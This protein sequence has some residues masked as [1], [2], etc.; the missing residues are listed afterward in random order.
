M[1]INQNDLWLS[2]PIRLGD[3]QALS[4]AGKELISQLVEICL[5]KG[6]VPLCAINGNDTRADSEIVSLSLVELGD[7]ASELDRIQ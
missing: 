5:A 3:K 6:R 7:L 1:N 4:D 2:T